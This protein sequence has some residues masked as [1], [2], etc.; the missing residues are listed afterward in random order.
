MSLALRLNCLLHAFIDTGI[1]RLYGY[2]SFIINIITHQPSQPLI[3]NER[4][5]TRFRCYIRYSLFSAWAQ[6]IYVYMFPSVPVYACVTKDVWRCRHDL[7]CLQAYKYTNI[8]CI[9]ICSRFNRV[10]VVIFVFVWEYEWY[11]S[12]Q[13]QLIRRQ[14]QSEL[15]VL[16]TKHWHKTG[17][18][19][20]RVKRD[21][22]LRW[23]HVDLIHHSCMCARLFESTESMGI[24]ILWRN[25]KPRSRYIE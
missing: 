3:A 11:M 23:I 22:S 25:W 4:A 20:L 1:R 18:V 13:P 17:Q 15:T 12:Q 8:V 7:T 2:C 9:C 14:L 5:Y 10:K 16:S 19:D 21:I 6:K 24:A